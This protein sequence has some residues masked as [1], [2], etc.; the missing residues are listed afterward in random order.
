MDV[1]AGVTAQFSSLNDLLISAQEGASAVAAGSGASGGIAT[2]NGT[3]S[4]VGNATID[5]GG[6]DEDAQAAA[7]EAAAAAVAVAASELTNVLSTMDE[8]DSGAAQS[9]TDALS[10]LLDVQSASQGS[11]SSAAGGENIAAAV[12]Q[13]ARAT[14]QAATAGALNGTAE[15]VV[16]TSSNLNM[17]VNVRPASEVSAAPI[18][19][20][21]STGTPA[22]VHMPSDALDSV[23]GVDPTRPIAAILR[24]SNVNLHSDPV[25]TGGV[26]SRR[27]R[28]LAASTGAGARGN[29]STGPTVTFSL[30]Q[31]GTELSLRD[32]TTPINIS[33]AYRPTATS[34]ARP[35]CIGSA[36]DSEAAAA[37]DTTIEC[38]FWNVTLDAWST[39]GCTT[40]SADDGSVGCSCTHLTEFIAFEFPT[41][42]DELLAAVLSSVA[43]NSLD[44]E[45]MQCA[46]DPSRSFST[47][48]VVWGCIFVL[49][50]LFFTLLGNA[51]YHDRVD[52]RRTIAL[53]AGKNKD[54]EKKRLLKRQQSSLRRQ[55]SSLKRQRSSLNRRDSFMTRSSRS[56]ASDEDAGMLSRG[57]S[58]LTRQATRILPNPRCSTSGAQSPPP[59][60][61]PPAV[62]AWAEEEST[63]TVSTTTVSS[64]ASVSSPAHSGLGKNPFLKPVTAASAGPSSKGELLKRLQRSSYTIQNERRSKLMAERWH[65]DVDAVWKRLCLACITDHSLCAGILR[66]GAAG[67]TRA[68]TVMILLNGFSF[69][70][71]MLC[72]F[73]PQPEAPLEYNVTGTVDDAPAV[74]INPVAIVF[75]ATVA[76]AICIPMML[77]FAWLF[78]PI[79]FVNIT[80][81]LVR[82]I[83]GSPF[84]FCRRCIKRLRLSSKPADTRATKLPQGEL[85]VLTSSAM[86]GTAWKATDDVQDVPMSPPLVL[87]EMS[88]IYSIT[89]ILPMTSSPEDDEMAEAATTMQASWRM[90]DTQRKL[91][92]AEEKEMAAVKLQSIWRTLKTRRM[93]AQALVQHKLGESATSVQRAWHNRTGRM[94]PDVPRQGCS[95]SAE[96]DI[97][98]AIADTATPPPSPPDEVAEDATPNPKKMVLK[99]QMTQGTID[100][101]ERDAKFSYESFDEGQLKASLSESWKRKDWPAVKKILLGWTL[102]YLCFF[103]MLFT[104]ACYGCLLFEDRR[105]TPADAPPGNTD[106]LIVSWILSA[107]QR[108]VLHEPTLILAAKGLPI[109]FASEFCANC[110]GESI[111]NCL[112]ILFNIIVASFKLLKKA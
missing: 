5:G 2:A 23:A 55:Q 106:E 44:M 67:L 96:S 26:S 57:K 49:F 3:E 85:T 73:F 102:S 19:C 74:V 107:G 72:L 93:W 37:C 10:S 60:P 22:A 30:L 101:I 99:R 100:R 33:L 78:D 18:A 53:L 47:V 39:A 61:P 77:I 111:V 8:L 79:I 32:L 24:T 91:R 83:I 56:S 20:N 34:A 12:D 36:A 65:K 42:S 28:L 1:V 41:S 45:A 40:T 7:A 43:F 109:L 103:S 35:P 86:H 112:S 62:T 27:R 15:P 31:D 104:F 82:V 9:V 25:A 38:R 58:F 63:T 108:F 51:I 75:G 68:Q 87:A 59:S 52:I 88:P 90:H 71:I 84:W 46:T 6:D 66:K 29:T 69:E 94:R 14:A 16:L 4:A 95:A 98:A 89:P 92:L 97:E 13:M 64:A 81:N 17:S 11:Q 70:L 48:P 76:A 105:E 50:F 21:S 110:C 54:E 80:R